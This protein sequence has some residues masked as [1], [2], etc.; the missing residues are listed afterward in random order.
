LVASLVAAADVFLPPLLDNLVARNLQSRLGLAEIPEISL[1]SDPVSL[2]TGKF[3]GGRVA[4]PGVEFGGV[5]PEEASVELAPFDLDVLRSLTSGQLRTHTPLSGTLRMELSEAEVVR[6]AGEE[7]TSFPVSD[8]DLEEGVAMVDSEV[9][10]LGKSI[11]V[12]VEGTLDLQNNSLVFEPRRVEAFGVKVPDRL[13]R[14]LL[15]GTSFVYPLE[16]LPGGDT[17]TGVEVHKDQLI[18]TGEIDNLTLL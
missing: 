17:F 7:A 6:L 18:L 4:L 12:S 9:V 5:R 11:P 14:Q 2:L 1:D 13:T 15:Q 8:V 16:P 3:H 10:V